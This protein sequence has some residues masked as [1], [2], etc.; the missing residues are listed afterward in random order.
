MLEVLIRGPVD[1]LRALSGPDLA[2]EQDRVLGNEVLDLILHVLRDLDEHVLSLGREVRVQLELGRALHER[3]VVG[4]V[5]QV[6]HRHTEPLLGHVSALQD[7][8]S[9]ALQ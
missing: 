5:L 3:L 1:F 4:R 6:L 8:V 9:D 7:V 2:R